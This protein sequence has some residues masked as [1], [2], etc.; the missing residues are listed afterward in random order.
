MSECEC[1]MGGETSFS[2]GELQLTL[3]VCDP[4]HFPCMHTC[5]CVC[6]ALTQGSSGPIE[7]R[8]LKETPALAKP[9]SIPSPASCES[10]PSLTVLLLKAP[11]FPLPHPAWLGS[12]R[13]VPALVHCLF[14]LP[15]TMIWEYGPC[16]VCVCWACPQVPSPR[17][18]AAGE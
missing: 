16:P 7:A 9:L 6:P 1:E 4:H 10:P 2:C 14:V 18:L 3:A 5:V 11:P 13:A 15:R 8:K 12:L 17:S